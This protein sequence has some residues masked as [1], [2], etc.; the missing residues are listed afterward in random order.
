MLNETI[1]NNTYEGSWDLCPYHDV[2]DKA[3]LQ[4]LVESMQTNGWQG[5]PLVQHGGQLMTG[6]HRYA[7]AEIAF[8]DDYTFKLPIVDLTDVFCI[9]DEDLED[10]MEQDCWVVELTRLA[11]QNNAELA[12]QLGM[13]AH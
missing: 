2:M 5:A 1:T 11:Q 12:I 10:A 13:D 7:A 9:D 4:S 8:A 6:S 3:L